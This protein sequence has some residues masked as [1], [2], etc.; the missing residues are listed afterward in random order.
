MSAEAA[1]GRGFESFTGESIE[2]KR[3][4]F[5]IRRAVGSDLPALVALLRDDVLGA[6]RE[7]S[8]DAGNT[9]GDPSAASVADDSTAYA[10]AFA[11]IAD[12]P[13]QLLVSVVEGSAADEHTTDAPDADGRIVGTLQL[14][15]VPSLSR[16]GTVRLQIEAVRIGAAAQGNGL[17]TAVFEWAHDCGRRFGAGLAQLTTDKSRADAQRFYARLG[18]VASHE[19]LKLRLG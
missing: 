7:G 14:S 9:A 12:D 13:N 15:L 19:G 4:R 17:G 1:P 18:Y 5:T 16:R 8:A 11:L 3:R 6:A 10:E 2:V